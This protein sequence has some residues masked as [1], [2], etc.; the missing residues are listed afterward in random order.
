VESRLVS[1]W[2]VATAETDD[3]HRAPPSKEMIA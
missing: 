3:G 2:T 1:I